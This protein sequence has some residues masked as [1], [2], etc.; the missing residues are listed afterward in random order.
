MG[1]CLIWIDAG[2]GM[3][4]NEWEGWIGGMEGGRDGAGDLRRGK[5]EE[6]RALAEDEEGDV[7]RGLGIGKG[8]GLWERGGGDSWCSMEYVWAVFEEVG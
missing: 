5:R 8:T 3:G 7:G 6:A 4:K 2:M 1:K